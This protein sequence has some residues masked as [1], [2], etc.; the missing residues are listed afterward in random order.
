MKIIFS[1]TE[2]IDIEYYLTEVGISLTS[3]NAIIDG[4]TVTFNAS[5]I[6]ACNKLSKS[7]VDEINNKYDHIIT[8]SSNAENGEYIMDINDDFTSEYLHLCASFV[9]EI[10]REVGS[11]ITSFKFIIEP[12]IERFAKKWFGSKN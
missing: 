7:K 6:R 8:I 1:A 4:E 12:I 5:D 3:L 10:T 2:L 9:S 11:F